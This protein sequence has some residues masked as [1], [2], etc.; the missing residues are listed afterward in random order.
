MPVEFATAVTHTTAAQAAR[1]FCYLVQPTRVR[2][3]NIPSQPSV[4]EAG[5]IP[6][7]LNFSA[8][9]HEVAERSAR[10]FSWILSFETIRRIFTAEL[11]AVHQD[12][13]VRL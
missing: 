11:Y 13:P 1:S 8:R 5:E 4:I 3:W 7:P 12:Q 6:G 10:P 2:V 9:L